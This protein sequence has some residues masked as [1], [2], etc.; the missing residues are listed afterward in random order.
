MRRLTQTII[1]ALQNS[2]KLL[3]DFAEHIGLK[4]ATVE[5][6]LRT[7]KLRKLST[8]LAE[9]YLRRKLKLPKTAEVVTEIDG[10]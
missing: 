1:E 3:G 2:P 5:L 9:A 7:G 8:P 4:G 6:Y 10:N